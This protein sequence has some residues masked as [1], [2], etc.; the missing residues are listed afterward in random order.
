MWRED[1]FPLGAVA[2]VWTMV[3]FI[4]SCLVAAAPLIE[5]LLA[6]LAVGVA[7]YVSFAILCPACG[8]LM[9]PRPAKRSQK[10]GEKS[11]SAPLPDDVRRLRA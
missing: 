1:D 9:V 5:T 11:R 7:T 3:L 10:G 8:R 4:V 6:G 2:S